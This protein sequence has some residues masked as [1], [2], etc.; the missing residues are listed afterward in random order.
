MSRE[1]PPERAFALDDVLARAGAAVVR[2]RD[3]R[4]REREQTGQR[5]EQ[6]PHPKPHESPPS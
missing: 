4:S 5:V 3:E 6:Q 2:V 1:G